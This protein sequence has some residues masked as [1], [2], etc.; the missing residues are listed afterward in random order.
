MLNTLLQ[1]LAIPGRYGASSENLAE[2]QYDSLAAIMRSFGVTDAQ[3]EPG[4][5]VPIFRLH[6]ANATSQG[7]ANQPRVA[8]DQF[9]ITLSHGVY[10]LAPHL[11]RRPGFNRLVINFKQDPAHGHWQLRDMDYRRFEDQPMRT[12]SPSG[13]NTRDMNR[14][15]QAA[16]RMVRQAV[17]A[18]PDGQPASLDRFGDVIVAATA[19][20]TTAIDPKP[21]TAATP[22]P[23]AATAA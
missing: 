9:S 12:I 5:L 22:A 10:N 20:Q 15:L 13:H 11:T 1:R 17:K 14:I 16:Q 23:G 6:D 4:H 18:G 8:Q 3:P 19:R 7:S 2:R 21:A